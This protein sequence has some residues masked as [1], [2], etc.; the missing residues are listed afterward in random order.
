MNLLGWREILLTLILLVVIYMVWLVWR[1]RRIGRQAPAPHPRR[2]EPRVSLNEPSIFSERQMR[3][4]GKEADDDDDNGEDEEEKGE[5]PLTYASLRRRNPFAVPGAEPVAKS[6][7]KP[8]END[9]ARQDLAR[10]AIMTGVEREVGQLRDEMDALRG[11]FA[12]LRGDVEALRDAFEQEVQNLHKVQNASP[13]YSD[14]MQMAM[15]GHDAVTIAERCGISRAEAE[16]V[17]ALMNNK[18]QS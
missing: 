11:A 1:M 12:S 7:A 13:L 8:E 3:E 9:H 14:A 15:L 4:Q 6:A 17:V 10:Q 18:D 16:L 2:D 5:R